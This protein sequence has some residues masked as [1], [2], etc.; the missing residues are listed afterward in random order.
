MFKWRLSLLASFCSPI[1]EL[2]KG[3]HNAYPFKTSILMR[4]PHWFGAL[5]PVESI[6]YTVVHHFVG[7]KCYFQHM[8]KWR[9]SSLSS[10]CSPINEVQKGQ[11]NAYPFKKSLECHNILCLSY[12][13]MI[14]GSWR[15]KLYILH[16][17]KNPVFSVQESSFQIIQMVVSVLQAT[18]FCF[19]SFNIVQIYF[20][21]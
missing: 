8:F 10:F 1:N 14:K 17:P 7:E 4:L 9:L 16:V 6:S 2:Q 18:Q 20:V 21:S 15:G 19:F 13:Y 12:C 3:Q 5:R 11:H